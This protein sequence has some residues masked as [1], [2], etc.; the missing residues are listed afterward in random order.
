[1]IMADSKKKVKKTAV[2]KTSKKKKRKT[3]DTWKKKSWYTVVSPKDFESKE[4][5]NTPA[6]KPE[7]V[8]GR[9]IKVPLREITGNISH[10]SITMHF[11]VNEVKGTTAYT[12]TNGFEMVREHFRRNVRRGRSM[13]TAIHYVKTKDKK[14]AQVTA[15]L[16]TLGRINTERKDVIRKV[17]EETLEETAK[18]VSLSDLVKKAAFGEL[19]A[20]MKKKAKVFCPVKMAIVSKVEV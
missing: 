2:K 1:M 11:K 18:G 14:K 6:I 15:H 12:E 19:G 17:M 16:F 10:Q 9:V 4:V 8:I 13:V 20:E 3:T 7:L 5:G